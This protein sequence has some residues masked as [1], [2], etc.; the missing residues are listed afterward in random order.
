MPRDQAE[1]PY[2][3]GAVY[4]QERGDVQSSL[5][6]YDQERDTAEVAWTCDNA[7]LKESVFASILGNIHKPLIAA[8]TIGIGFIAAALIKPNAPSSDTNRSSNQNVSAESL[9]YAQRPPRILPR[10]VQNE[11]DS[12]LKVDYGEYRGS[13]VKVG[14]NLVWTAGHMVMPAGAGHPSSAVCSYDAKTENVNSSLG[15]GDFIQNWYGQYNGPN[16]PN[17]PDFALLSVISDSGFDR[18]PTASIARSTPSRG[19]LA[20]FINYESNAKGTIARFPSQSESPFLGPQT[21]SHA[22]EYAGIILGKF[23]G[24]YEVAGGLQG[25]GPARGREENSHPG[26]SG[27]PVFNTVGKTEGVV[28]ATIRNGESVGQIATDFG[29]V[30]PLPRDSTVGVSLVQPISSTLLLGVESALSIDEAC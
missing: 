21:Y 16:N 30:L 2:L 25:Y 28:I 7:Q 11:Y 5:G 22:A 6:P 8:S 18:L 27:G 29:V 4:D 12:V 17:Y 23:N 9:T 3:N 13:G 24:L 1:S 20:Y 15:N 10:L 19:D 26:A 14:P